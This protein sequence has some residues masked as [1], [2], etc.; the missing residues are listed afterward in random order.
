MGVNVHNFSSVL[1]RIRIRQGVS[2]SRFCELINVPLSTYKNWEKGLFLP[3]F[4][5]YKLLVESLKA[6]NINTVELDLKY[7]NA[8]SK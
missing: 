4:K 2:Q 1:K 6:L 8:K 7:G 3:G 5:N